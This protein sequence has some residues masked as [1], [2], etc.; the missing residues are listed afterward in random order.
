MASFATVVA[1][2]VLT[3][4]MLELPYRIQWLNKFDRAEV[5]GERCYILGEHDDDWLAY[6]PD[7]PPPRNRVVKRTDPTV[8]KTGLVE[9]IFASPETSR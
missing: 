9:S 7:R 5:A 6:C 3:V 4:F 8:R 2:F 1:M